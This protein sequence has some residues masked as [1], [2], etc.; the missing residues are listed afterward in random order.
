MSDNKM[1]Q[2]VPDAKHPSPEE[3]NFFCGAVA[4]GDREAIEGFLKKYDSAVNVKDGY[5]STALMHAAWTGQKDILL[6]LLDRGA[7][8][9]A[10]DKNGLTAIMYAVEMEIVTLLHERGARPPRLA[11]YARALKCLPEMEKRFVGE[12][13]ASVTDARL[14]KLKQM[15][16][17]KTILKRNPP[18]SKP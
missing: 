11:D 16:P 18:G 10:K 1:T 3:V 7:D 12:I 13:T 5:G 2:P 4:G 17:Q 9:H 14:N 8:V 15:K 6:F